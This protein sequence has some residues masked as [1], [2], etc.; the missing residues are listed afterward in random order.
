MVAVNGTSVMD[1]RLQNFN[2]MTWVSDTCNRWSDDFFVVSEVLQSLNQSGVQFLSPA[3]TFQAGGFNTQPYAAPSPGGFPMQPSPGG[4]QVQPSP[5]GIQMQSM[6]FQGT[7][8]GVL[9]LDITPSEWWEQEISNIGL[10]KRT[11]G[12]LV[13]SYS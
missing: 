6:G 4:F 8:S 3:S 7:S 1:N 9:R 12:F 10:N 11:Y 13:S 5:N 2:G